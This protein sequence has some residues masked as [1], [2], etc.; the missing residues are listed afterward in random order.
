MSYI[1]IVKTDVPPPNQTEADSPPSAGVSFD[2]SLGDAGAISF[3]E[4][5]YRLKSALPLKGEIASPPPLTVSLL[6]GQGLHLKKD[7]FDPKVARAKAD[8]ALE[9]FAAYLLGKAPS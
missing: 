8:A 1:K 9:A 7:R 3:N 6:H 2:R 5:G 4:G